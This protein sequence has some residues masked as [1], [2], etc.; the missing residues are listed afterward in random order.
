MVASRISVILLQ[1][2]EF[3]I[4]MALEREHFLFGWKLPF[5]WLLCHLMSRKH[6]WSS[7]LVMNPYPQPGS[8]GA[9]HNPWTLKKGSDIRPLLLSLV[10]VTSTAPS[11][12]DDPT[13]SRPASLLESIIFYTITKVTLGKIQSAHI[14]PLPKTF[15]GCHSIQRK[16]QN[17][18]IGTQ[19]VWLIWSRFFLPLPRTAASM[20]S[21]PIWD[22]S[23]G[24]EVTKN[25]VVINSMQ[26]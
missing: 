12:M 7:D 21:W 5:F 15:K 17:P 16:S 24:T 2:K 18:H 3:S 23:L 9:R 26:C 11:S 14:T 1:P 10:Q 4:S 25:Y 22:I 13:A 20:G 6:W 19:S 8:P